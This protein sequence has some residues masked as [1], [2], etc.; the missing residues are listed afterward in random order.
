MH[1]KHYRKIARIIKDNTIS[2]KLN[3]LNY[4]VLDKDNLIYDLCIVLKQDNNL[5]EKLRFMDAC[6]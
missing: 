6:E 2:K 5:F 4:D 3:K 1:R